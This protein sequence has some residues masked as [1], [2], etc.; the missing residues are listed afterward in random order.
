MSRL[1]EKVAIIT[2]GA[3]G[4]GKD[5]ASQFAREGAK[6]VITDI[7]QE[8]GRQVE[9]ELKEITDDVLFVQH[10]VSSEDEW[11]NV[12]SEATDAFGRIDVLFNNAGIY[13]IEDIPKIELETWNNLMDINVT[14]VFLGLKHVLPVMEENDN[15]GSVINASSVAGLAGTP[16]HLLYGA[17]KGAVRQMTKDAAAEYASKGVRVNSIHPGYITTGMADYASEATQMSKEELDSTYPLGRMGEVEEVANLVTF[18]AS[19]E[20]TFSTA[21]EFVIDGGAVNIN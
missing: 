2:G 5:T 16:G 3:S 12:V 14:G 18:L 4:I 15:G 20:S 10:D 13:I 8:A 6:V 17:S 19:D 21:G 11:K 9:E 1:S 7:D